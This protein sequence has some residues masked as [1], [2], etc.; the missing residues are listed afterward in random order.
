MVKHN[1]QAACLP[2][3][4]IK[5][6]GPSLLGRDWLSAL[7]LDWKEIFKVKTETSALVSVL[8]KHSEIFQ[9]D[10]GAVIGVK[11]KIHVDPQAQPRFHKARAVPFAF[12]EKV[13]EDL[14]RLQNL[15]IIE[16]VQFL[17][18]VPVPKG[19]GTVCI[20]SDYKVPVNQV[21]KLDKYPIPWIEELWR[22]ERLSRNLTSRMCIQ[23]VELDQ[24]SK[25][26]TISTHKGLFQ[27]NRLPFG[28]RRFFNA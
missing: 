5:G 19:D 13:E 11:A 16:P 10:T 26:F 15:G 4:V 24:E 6:K 2:L 22:A 3:I 25:Q 20:C 18:C 27:Y 21:A 9:D 8:E 17:D 14:K 7:R 12:R 28:R 23:Q 1:E